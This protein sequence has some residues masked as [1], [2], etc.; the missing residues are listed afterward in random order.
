MAVEWY[1]KAAAQGDESAMKQLEYL[2]IKYSVR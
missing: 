1:L 2:G